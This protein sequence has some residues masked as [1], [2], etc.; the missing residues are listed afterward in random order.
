M[1]L[2]VGVAALHLPSFRHNHDAGYTGEQTHG[3]DLDLRG[4]MWSV[5]EGESYRGGPRMKRTRYAARRDMH[6]MRRVSGG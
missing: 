4:M 2:N 3:T 6:V 5:H 1:P